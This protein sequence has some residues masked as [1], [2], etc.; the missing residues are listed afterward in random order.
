MAC[1]VA[2]LVVQVHGGTGYMR[3]IPVE[4]IFREVRL[5]CGRQTGGQPRRNRLPVVH[6]LSHFLLNPRRS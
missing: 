2:D 5:L 3:D 1:R 4:R 6:P